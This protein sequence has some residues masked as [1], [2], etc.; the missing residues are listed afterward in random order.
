MQDVQRNEAYERAIHRAVQ[1]LRASGHD[2]VTAL[3]IGAGSGLLSMMAARYCPGLFGVFSK[4]HQRGL[5]M[6]QQAKTV[7]AASLNFKLMICS[8]G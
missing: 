7:L 1:F 4:P 6:H 2:R 5:G 8:G 3:D